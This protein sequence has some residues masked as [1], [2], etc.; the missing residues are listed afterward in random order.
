MN[1]GKIFLALT[2][3]FAFGSFFIAPTSTAAGLGRLLFWGMAVIHV[4]EFTIFLPAV[5]RAGGSIGTHFVKVLAFGFLHLQEIGAF[6]K[7]EDS[8]G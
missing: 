8:S 6:S 5:R 7:S 1:P 4:I 3:A 2:W